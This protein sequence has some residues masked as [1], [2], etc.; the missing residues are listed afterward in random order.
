MMLAFLTSAMVCFPEP[1]HPPVFAWDNQA[2]IA[3]I[4]SCY[5]RQFF[6]SGVTTPYLQG[7][8]TT[9]VRPDFGTLCLRIDDE[10]PEGDAFGFCVKVGVSVIGAMD[11]DQPCGEDVRPA[12]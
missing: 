5:G 6:G 3:I 1:S 2:P 9:V 12:P 11:P 10:P 4:M 7:C 8:S